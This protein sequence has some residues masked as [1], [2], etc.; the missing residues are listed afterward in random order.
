MDTRPL[1]G[2]VLDFFEFED[3]AF[4]G[5]RRELG[6]G[7]DGNLGFDGLVVDGQREHRFHNERKDID[8]GLHDFV[9]G[10][11]TELVGDR[12]EEGLDEYGVHVR[13]DGPLGVGLT[14]GI[15]AELGLLVVTFDGEGVLDDTDDDGPLF[16]DLVHPGGM[17]GE[18]TFDFL[19][20]VHLVESFVE[21][22]I[23]EGDTVEFETGLRGLALGHDGTPGVLAEAVDLG[24]DD[25]DQG[26]D[27]GGVVGDLDLEGDG[28]GLFDFFLELDDFGGGGTCSLVGC[29]GGL[30]WRFP[31]VGGCMLW[32]VRI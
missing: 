32:G 2:L 16:G 1:A 19:V 4:E 13:A 15:E 8:P 10:L 30:G 12:V 6:L 9:R 11:G 7:V 25:G 31:M 17:G 22:I 27:G 28:I 26:E 21:I 20:F 3:L 24:V 5:V 29:G 23:E 18:D 14:E